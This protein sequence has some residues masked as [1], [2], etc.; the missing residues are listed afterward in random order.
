MIEI[1]NCL[2]CWFTIRV[3][4]LLSNMKHDF[5]FKLYSQVSTIKDFKTMLTA[6]SRNPSDFLR[7]ITINVWHFMFR[8][9][10]FHVCLNT[11]PTRT[12]FGFFSF[13]LNKL[14]ILKNVKAILMLESSLDIAVSA[15]VLCKP[16]GN[17][18]LKYWL[19][20]QVQKM[21]YFI[22]IKNSSIF[23]NVQVPLKGPVWFLI[24]VSYFKHAWYVL[25]ILLIPTVCLHMRNPVRNNTLYSV[26]FY[27]ILFLN[28]HLHWFA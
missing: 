18:R 8:L 17:F 22:R 1:S 13:S 23:S 15:F 16:L 7:C 27:G 21:N 10:L 2:I 6:F 26:N 5:V 9:T 3:D 28:L 25:S 20:S 12:S 11:T 4:F 19:S 24:R 14:P